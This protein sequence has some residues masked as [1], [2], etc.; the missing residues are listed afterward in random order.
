MS[1]RGEFLSSVSFFPQR[2]TR[3]RDTSRTRQA[4]T[5][6]PPPKKQLIR[7]SARL[8]SKPPPSTPN[9]RHRPGTPSAHLSR[10]T[11]AQRHE[12]R[13][14]STAAAAAP[15]PGEGAAEVAAVLPVRVGAAASLHRRR[16]QLL[17]E[18]HVRGPGPADRR[19]GVVQEVGLERTRGGIEVRGVVPAE[20][21]VQQ[22]RLVALSHLVVGMQVRWRGRRVC[23]RADGNACA[24][25]VR[26]DREMGGFVSR[27]ET[28]ARE[29]GR[30]N[31]KVACGRACARKGSCSTYCLA[32]RPTISLRRRNAPAKALLQ[33][34]NLVAKTPNTIHTMIKKKKKKSA[35]SFCHR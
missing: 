8:V 20:G 10:A 2:Y 13:L 19:V 35:Q 31:N 11:G 29:G 5:E 3:R 4:T 18:G 30:G 17:Q 12:V 28:H 23:G 34:K 16:Q 1:A 22:K 25:E 14:V 27:E 21:N 7:W 32:K 26:T 9:Y 33:K 6:K 24:L 15:A